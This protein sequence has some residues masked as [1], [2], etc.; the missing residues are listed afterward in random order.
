MR[1]DASSPASFPAVR[2]V[3]VTGAGRGIGAAAALMAAQRGWDVA[4][5]FAR[6][7]SSA[8]RIAEAVQDAGRRS[9]LLRAGTLV[10]AS[11]AR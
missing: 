8:A 6:D 7:E 4:V 9:L 2:S 10:D 11:G 5:N 1:Q 3:L